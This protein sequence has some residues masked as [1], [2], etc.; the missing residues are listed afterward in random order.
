MAQ[1][2]E[3][4]ETWYCIESASQSRALQVY[5]EVHLWLIFFWK[6]VVL[7]DHISKGLLSEDQI[8]EWVDGFIISNGKHPN[9]HSGKV[10]GA[11]ET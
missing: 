7:R 8:L 5:R 1:V 9:L 4:S 2:V 10:D 6:I 3:T 11:S